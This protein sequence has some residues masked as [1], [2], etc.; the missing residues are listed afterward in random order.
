MAKFS[1]EVD[2]WDH[3]HALDLDLREG[4]FAIVRD[5]LKESRSISD[6]PAERAVNDKLP[7]DRQ[8]RAA[9]TTIRELILKGVL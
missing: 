5:G 2:A 4:A 6:Y 8:R 1:N 9:N 7:V 3:I